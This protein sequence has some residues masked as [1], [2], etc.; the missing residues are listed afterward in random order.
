MALFDSS[1]LQS[2]VKGREVLSW[3]LYDAA[4]SGYTT[5][6][7]T[8]VFNAYFVSTVCGNATW[9]TF[10][11]SCAV[12]LAN[13]LCMVVMPAVGRLA[14][15]TATK[16]KWLAGATALCVSATVLLSFSG[17]GTYVLAVAMVA[18]SS[19]GYNL[20]ES[21]SSSFL[22]EI[23]RPEAIGRISGWGWS[24][25][26]VGGLLT[27]ALCLG[28][29]LA[30]QQAGLPV[31]V[32]VGASCL[33]TA[34]W[35]ALV[36]VPC[37]VFLKE[38]A[39]PQRSAMRLGQAFSEAAAEWA[40]TMRHLKNYPDFSRLAL[41]GFLYQCGIATVIALV[42]IFASAVV[43]FTM[44]QTLILMILVNI[45]A[46]FGAFAFGYVQDKLG[47]KPALSIT[48]CLWIAMALLAGMAESEWAFWI[49]AN[50]A[51]LAMGSSQSAG[52]AMVGLL[53]PAKRLAQFYG[54]WNMAL[55]MAAIV[56]PLFY[57]ALTWATGNNHRLA[58][59]CTGAFFVAGL[60]VLQTVD[61]ARGCRQA[62]AE[63][64]AQSHG[65]AQS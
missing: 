22:P 46:A 17:P 8:A 62:A 21:L 39:V 48:L 53:A 57:G 41:C 54:F 40:Q 12:A 36:A 13:A 45:T 44:T 63:D 5:V 58:I 10:L 29:S 1:D 27:L 64:A 3:A 49:A 7:V 18:L 33:I 25:G 11:W 37:F 23:A 52:R 42:A 56:G 15:L 26:Y 47:H 14:D 31:R 6:V 9:A 60:I 2:G 16:K 51:G 59:M 50:A 32:Q 35:Y 4:S 38:R 19:V 20:G 43:G 34:G 24:V 30:G 55:W 28:V 65:P 61:M